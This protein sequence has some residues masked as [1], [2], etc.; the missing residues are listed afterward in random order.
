M[1]AA[2]RPARTGSPLVSTAGAVVQLGI[3]NNTDRDAFGDVVLFPPPTLPSSDDRL[4]SQDAPATGEPH[5]ERVAVE[6][7]RTAEPATSHQVELPAGHAAASSFLDRAVESAP[8]ERRARDAGHDEVARPQQLVSLTPSPNVANAPQPPTLPSSTPVAVPPP[9]DAQFAPIVV[10]VPLIL[11]PAPAPTPTPTLAPVSATA[12]PPR[13]ASA[14]SPARVPAAASL[15]AAKPAANPTPTPLP[16]GASTRASASASAAA[17]DHAASPAP[18]TEQ[19][20]LLPP[21]SSSSGG[22][23]TMG[24]SDAAANSVAAAAGPLHV[25]MMV[26][27]PDPN[28]DNG[29]AGPPPPGLP[30]FDPA[31]P[32]D[33][34][35]NG[36]GGYGGGMV[37]TLSRT[38]QRMST[39][40]SSTPAPTF[41]TVPIHARSDLAGTDDA[42]TFLHNG[43]STAKYTPWSFLPK[44]LRE[45]FGKY[46]NVFFLFTACIQQIPGISPTN[47][48]DTITPLTVV[49]LFTAAKEIAEDLRRHRADDEVNQCNV[50]VLGRD[51]QLKTVVWQD[52]AV[53]DIVRVEN[54]ES[55]PADLV[56][57]ASSEQDGLCYIETAN[58]DGETNLKIKQARPETANWVH[59]ADLADVR[60]RIECELPNSSLYTFE[61]TMRVDGLGAPIALDPKQVLLRGA[62]LRNT[63]W[64]CGVVVYTGHETKLMRNASAAPIKTTALEGATNRQI[65]VLCGLLL[66]MALACSVG[67]QVLTAEWTSTAW[68][69]LLGEA[70]LSPVVLFLSNLATFWVLFNNLIPISLIVT[71][72]MVKFANADLIASDLQMY[73]APADMPAVVRTSSLVEELGQVQYIFSDKTGTLTC[74]IMQFM[75]CTIGGVRYAESVPEPAPDAPMATFASLRGRLAYAAAQGGMMGNHDATAHEFL[76]LLSVC[77]TVLPEIT[78][79]GSV[80]YQASSPDEAALVSG[81]ADLG[82]KFVARKPNSVTIEVRRPRADSHPDDVE[83]VTYAVLAVNEFNSTRKRMSVL[84]ERNG[85]YRLYVKG[86]D[87]VI[88]ARLDQNHPHTIEQQAPTLHALEYYATQG[89]RTLTLAYRQLTKAQADAWLVEFDQASTTLV[90]RGDALM[91]VAES[92]E[93]DLVLLGATAIEDKL[94]DG[95][96]E[97]IATL[98]KANLKLWVLTG[99]RQETA[100]NI[101]FSCRLLTPS[102]VLL[103]INEPSPAAIARRIDEHKA[104]MAADP[105]AEYALVIEGA[106]LAHVLPD[107]TPVASDAGSTRSSIEKKK[108]AWP[109][110]TAKKPKVKAPVVPVDNSLTVPFAELACA[111]HVVIACRTSPLQKSQVV[112]M[113]K[114]HV[115]AITLAIGDGA[116]DVSMIQAAHIGIG[117]SGQEGLQAAR[118]ADV[119][120]GQF[121]YLQRLLLVHGCYAYHR[122]VKLILFSFYKNITLYLTQFWF[123]VFNGFSGQT[124]YETWILTGFNVFFTSIPPL[125]LGIFDKVID[126]DMLESTPSLYTVHQS[127]RKFNVKVFA[128]WLVN[129]LYHSTAIFFGTCYVFGT[130]DLGTGTH[131]GTMGDHVRAD[132]LIGGVWILGVVMYTSVLVTVL[133]KAM[134][135]TSYWAAPWTFLAIFGSLAL[136]IAFLPIYAIVGG[137]MISLSPE[138]V[139]AESLYVDPRFWLAVVLVA[140]LVLLRDLAVKFYR[141]WFRPLEM[142]VRREEQKLLHRERRRRVSGAVAPP[143]RSLIGA[144]VELATVASPAPPA[145]ATAPRGS[146]APALPMGPMVNSMNTPPPPPRVSSA[147]P[148]S[149]PPMQHTPL[150]SPQGTPPPPRGS[151][152]A[153]VTPAH[154]ARLTSL[155]RSSYAFS[156]SP[157]QGTLLHFDSARPRPTGL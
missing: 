58:L 23:T 127:G 116:N 99:D 36:G 107:E 81:A 88:L 67:T 60:G 148:M 108:S 73:Y 97:T 141:H 21:S 34:G 16:R 153:G 133:L 4:F 69:L 35:G 64:I 32:H 96:P 11:S 83:A 25:K 77:H 100:I 144:P 140:V 78:E 125:A 102:M 41:R 76:T 118:A 109:W 14:R 72:E 103:I 57:L 149:T 157:G 105:E 24:A 89:L 38:L 95:V 20:P 3:D 147:S 139:G 54:G 138:L 8:A 126:E 129:A 12:A 124:V 120:I 137:K 22:Q 146:S 18:A 43:I 52:V 68:Y 101:G 17:R 128:M 90:N 49:L 40:L 84:V 75:E 45:Q 145:A 70:S 154:L 87:N 5:V 63:H 155:H 33:S 55:F 86:A 111:C 150:S 110:G 142:H 122:L 104:T 74:N 27:N 130:W 82:Y 13:Q 114:A 117:I 156:Q 51:A 91:D 2:R 132:G 26:V 85:E 131:G 50:Q 94:Q 47:R 46:A 9:S 66:F 143:R 113:V 119:A 7:D 10:D 152:A 29:P 98:A 93:K 134:L 44:F 39:V 28:G 62:R 80:V 53:G 123:A 6:S 115:N 15:P 1:P 92:V 31:P 42:P 121:R 112:K 79:N 71:M 135:I 65:L 61:G 151:S 19:I 37:A 136:W 56:L 59:A 30:S 106:S 48:F